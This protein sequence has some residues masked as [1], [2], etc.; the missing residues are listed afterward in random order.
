MND[1]TNT[2]YQRHE[3]ESQSENNLLLL[4]R[5]RTAN[6]LQHSTTQ[7]NKTQQVIHGCRPHLHITTVFGAHIHT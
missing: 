1:T 2:K 5:E 6:A 3:V 7:G 4:S